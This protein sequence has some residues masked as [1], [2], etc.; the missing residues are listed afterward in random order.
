MKLNADIIYEY[1]KKEY[2]VEMYGSPTKR[3][4]LGKAELY[5]DNT[6]HFKADHVYLA[7]VEHLPQRPTIEKNV[8]LICIG[9][10]AR[11]NYYKE[12]ATVILIKKKQDFFRVYKSLQDLFETYHAWEEQLLD[13]FTRS[14][15]I[16]NV[17]NASID[18]FHR[19]LYVLDSSFQVVAFAAP[20]SASGGGVN[21][22]RM[23]GAPP[24]SKSSHR[25]KNNLDPAALAEYLSARGLAMDAKDPLLFSM[26]DG[27]HFLCVN[28]FDMND[29]YSGCLV[30]NYDKDEIPT[31]DELVAKRL[32]YMIEKI[33]ERNP[34]L[35]SSDHRALKEIV[36]NLMGELPLSGTQKLFL[37]SVNKKTEYLC[38]SFHCLEQLSALPV[39][40][41]CSVCESIFTESIFF[42]HNNSIQGLIPCTSLSDPANVY[43]SLKEQLATLLNGNFFSVGVSNAF[44]DLYNIRT[45]Y[46]QAEA[47][48]DNGALYQAKSGIYLFNDYALMELVS[49]ALGGMPAESYF[50]KGFQKLL[51]HDKEGGISYVETLTT[52]LEENMSYSKTARILYIHR[53]TLVER[54]ERIQNELD[55]DLDNPN[56]RLQIQILLKAMQIEEYFK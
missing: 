24:I 1:L 38:V 51:D 36:Q 29:N 19:M 48:L 5:I 18:V 20:A 31:G 28:L 52:F 27:N 7:T 45:Y 8:V 43:I 3:L 53:S 17:L 9:E 14:A 21:A 10:N 39:T 26:E 30:V 56:Q 32:A 54:I 42:E 25:R 35:I 47:A 11:L 12:H 49:N 34:V 37:K 40:Y 44:S 46:F 15:S 6:M 50:P 4:L 22:S 2:P 55:I 23:A 13:L 33:T 41:L 16:Q